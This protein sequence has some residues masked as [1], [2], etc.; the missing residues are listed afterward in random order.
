MVIVT[1]RPPLPLSLSLSLRGCVKMETQQWSLSSLYSHPLF[2]T[3]VSLVLL[4]VLYVPRPLLPLLFSP[5]LLSSFLLLFALL[6]LGP[7]PPEPTS[8]PPPKPTSETH[9]GAA[10]THKNPTFRGEFVEWGRRGGPLEVIYEEYE[11]G[12]E[13]GEEGTDSESESES[14]RGSAAEEEEEEEERAW[15]DS[16]V[17]PCLDWWEE[18][19]D[20]LIEIAIEEE[21]LIEIDISAGR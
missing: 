3:L 6:R 15:W 1:F 9:V 11:E 19:S 8:P 20:G 16:G 7:E 13:N 12:A 17:K 21:N 10:E 4:V 18:E 5:V 2:A 14:S